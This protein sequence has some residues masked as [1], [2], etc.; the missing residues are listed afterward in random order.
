MMKGWQQAQEF[1]DDCRRRV[2]AGFVQGKIFISTPFVSLL[3]FSLWRSGVS[4]Q[5]EPPGA[6]QSPKH[7]C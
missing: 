5:A 1:Q 4:I 7:T 3:K 2:L 6:V